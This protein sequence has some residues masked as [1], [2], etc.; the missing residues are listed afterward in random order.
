[1]EEVY[2]MAAWL[3]ANAEFLDVNP[4]DNK[5]KLAAKM[6]RE[7]AQE[8]AVLKRIYGNIQLR[9]EPLKIDPSKVMPGPQTTVSVAHSE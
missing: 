1:M 8:N 9:T 7:L 4:E 3:D 6:M 5:I 2:R